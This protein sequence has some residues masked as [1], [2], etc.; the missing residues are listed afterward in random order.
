MKLF[1]K[2]HNLRLSL[3]DLSTP[4]QDLR[5]DP[6][7]AQEAFSREIISSKKRWIFTKLLKSWMI[8]KSIRSAQS[9]Q[10]INQRKR[11]L[12][13]L[14]MLT[15]LVTFQKLAKTLLRKTDLLLSPR[16]SHPHLKLV[17]CPEELTFLLSR[18]NCKKRK[19]LVRSWR[20]NSMSLR[21]LALKSQVSLAKFKRLNKRRSEMQYNN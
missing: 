9:F 2:A 6:E 12:K 1:L 7:L 17:V 19:M 3:L 11:R 5:L 10:Q 21:R 14:N 18:T 20:V 15:M 8:Y 16:S 13:L 4:S